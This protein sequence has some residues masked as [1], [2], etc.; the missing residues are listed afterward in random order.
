V[1]E[2]Q[3]A[4]TNH[5]LGHGYKITVTICPSCTKQKER[6]EGPFQFQ[7]TAQHVVG[8]LGVIAFAIFFLI[9]WLP[10]WLEM[11]REHE[12]MKRR[13]EEFNRKFDEAWPRKP[14]GP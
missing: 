1:E 10:G 14:F 12:K 13:N 7:L 9:F 11:G 6:G 5:N 4:R 8:V 3:I 2:N